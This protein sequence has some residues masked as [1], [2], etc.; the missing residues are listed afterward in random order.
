MR[1]VWLLVR[2]A[3]LVLDG[4]AVLWIALSAASAGGPQGDAARFE[5]S[6]HAL[7]QAQVAR[8]APPPQAATV[9]AIG[10]AGWADQDV[11]IKELDG[12]LA[13]IGRILPIQDHTLRLVNDRNTGESL[14]LANQRNFAEAVH[15]LA[16]VMHRDA[17]ILLLLMTSHGTR[18]RIRVAP[19]ERGHQRA[20]AAAGRGNARPGGHQEPHRHRVG[21]LF[22]QLRAGAR[23]RRYDRAHRR[24]RQQHAR[25]AA[26]PS[27]TGPI[28]AM[29]CSGKAYGRASISS[30]R[31]TMPAP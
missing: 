17:D 4:A 27:A 18:Q 30:M 12:G 29:R 11:F 24:G 10:I 23:Q 21:V 5:R 13:A 19:A 6:Q 2:L 22:R 15:A 28:S 7:L 16:A 25:S 14:P 31:S 20:D 1:K 26:R 8:L 3:A 9:Y